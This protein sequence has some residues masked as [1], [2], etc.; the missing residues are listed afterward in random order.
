[1][2]TKPTIVPRWADTVSA[3]T[4][5]VNEPPDVKKDVGWVVAE[6]PPAQWFNWLL[7]YIYQWILWL[8]DYEN[9]AHT[10]TEQQ[11]FTPTAS[12]VDAIQAAAKGIGNAIS[13][14]GDTTA[15]SLGGLGISAMGGK[16]QAAGAFQGNGTAPAIR[17]IAGGSSTTAVYANG[18]LETD[19]HA[20][21]GLNDAATFLP[22]PVIPVGWA[23]IDSVV[24]ASG[25]I[26]SNGSWV[27]GKN[28][29]SITHSSSP[30]N[31]YL[32]EL[33]GNPGEYSAWVTVESVT[34]H[35]VTVGS[36]G[37]TS[38]RLTIQVRLL[39]AVGAPVESAFR[40]GLIAFG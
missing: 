40:F 24:Y 14:V 25:K 13:A 26:N 34:V 38:G 29:R 37:V 10:W 27:N 32:I 16:N 39:D 17:A 11:D 18:N 6:K 31:S 28:V 19:S 1:M 36:I 20:V 7:F 9:E 21:L 30:V 33:N 35:Q 4:T 12:N 8:A 5:K 15:V 2:A 22:A 23:G 3:D